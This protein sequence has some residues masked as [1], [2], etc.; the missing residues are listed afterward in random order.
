[1][2]LPIFLVYQDKERL[3][4]YREMR[5]HSETSTTTNICAVLKDCIVGRLFGASWGKGFNQLIDIGMVIGI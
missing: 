4:K 3:C 5:H 2:A 1:M